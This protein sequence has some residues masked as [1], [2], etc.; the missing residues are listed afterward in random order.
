MI[1]GEIRID[2]KGTKVRKA[3]RKCQVKL[4]FNI[5]LEY[6]HI[7]SIQFITM[8]GHLLRTAESKS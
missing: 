8:I 5:S 1:P 4:S 7:S 2:W 3:K 6:L